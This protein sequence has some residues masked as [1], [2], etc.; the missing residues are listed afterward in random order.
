VFTFDSLTKEIFPVRAISEIP[1]GLRICSIAIILPGSPVTSIIKELSA[2]KN[3][4]ENIE[5]KNQSL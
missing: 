4:N 3:D 5:F 2:M 1:N